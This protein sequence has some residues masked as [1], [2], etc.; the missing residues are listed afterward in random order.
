MPTCIK[1]KMKRSLEQGLDKC[2]KDGQLASLQMI[3]W[4][5]IT[6]LAAINAWDI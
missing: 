2:A 5:F 1:G 4:Q 6:L 3:W